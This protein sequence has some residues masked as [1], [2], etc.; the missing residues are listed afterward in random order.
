MFNFDDSLDTMFAWFDHLDFYYD[1]KPFFTRT[2]HDSDDSADFWRLENK[3]RD[4][5]KSFN[6]IAN[7]LQEMALEAEKTDGDN[8]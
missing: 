1:I 2:L 4:I 3:A 5:A 7:I 6:A 8:L